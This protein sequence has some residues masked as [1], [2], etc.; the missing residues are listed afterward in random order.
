MDEDVAD[1]LGEAHT[2][3][4]EVRTLKDSSM[5]DKTAVNRL[6]YACFHATR[7]ALYNR[8]HDPKTH[9]GI[10]VLLGKELVQNGALAATHGTFFSQL[11]DHRQRADYEYGPILADVDELLDRSTAFVEAMDALVDDP[12]SDGETGV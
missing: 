12:K 9:E 2:L 10:K 11:Y 6:Y 1:A 3:L 5:R 4:A 8:G 7:A